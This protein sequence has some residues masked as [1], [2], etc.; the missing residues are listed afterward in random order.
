MAGIERATDS[1]DERQ[2]EQVKEVCEGKAKL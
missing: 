2:G 1:D